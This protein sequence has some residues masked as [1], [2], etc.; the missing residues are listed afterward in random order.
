MQKTLQNSLRMFRTCPHRVETRNLHESDHLSR[1]PLPS[2]DAQRRPYSGEGLPPLSRTIEDP[3]CWPIGEAYFDALYEA[4]GHEPGLL[5]WDISNEPG[6]TDDFVTWYDE[7]PAYV[8]DYATRPNM[9]ELRA[10]QEKTWECV[11]QF[12]PL[13]Q[14]EGP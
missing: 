7:E 10:K 9:D 5:F 8:Q 4:I 13:C 12:L 14:S 2:E 3:S 1:I 11:R 6:Y